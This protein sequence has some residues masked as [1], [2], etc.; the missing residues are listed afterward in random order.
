MW[1]ASEKYNTIIWELQ[2]L[3]KQLLTKCVLDRYRR[4]STDIFSCEWRGSA[5]IDFFERKN[6]S[7]T[8]WRHRD[9]E[10]KKPT[11]VSES[12]LWYLSL[13]NDI[14][15]LQEKKNVNQMS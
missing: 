9:H 7:Q 14:S 11:H 13:G 1:D 12:G 5:P 4:G 10:V 6:K 8:I 15:L 3:T 2:I